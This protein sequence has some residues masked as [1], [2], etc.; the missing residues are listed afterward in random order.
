MLVDEVCYALRVSTIVKSLNHYD[1]RVLLTPGTEATIEAEG[2]RMAA[3]GDSLTIVPPGT[4][5]GTIERAGTAVRIFS[6]RA[7]DLAAKA[8]NAATYADRA[9]EVAPM[10]PWPDPVGGCR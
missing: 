2:E 10:V 9:P 6:N 8:V 3:K 7:A 4:S 1:Y 5:R